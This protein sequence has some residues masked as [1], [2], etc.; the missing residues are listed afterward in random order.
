MGR[1]FE[2]DRSDRDARY[3]PEIRLSGAE[4]EQDEIDLRRETDVFA[5]H[6]RLDGED[7]ETQ[8]AKLRDTLAEDAEGIIHL[9]IPAYRYDFTLNPFVGMGPDI[10]RTYQISRHLDV[11]FLHR[12]M[13]HDILVAGFRSR[14]YV[15]ET[16]RAAFV[17]HIRDTGGIVLQADNTQYDFLAIR[18]APYVAS[19]TTAAFF[20]LYHKQEPHSAERP[21]YPIDVWAIYDAQAYDEVDASYDFRR[22]YRLKDGY[23][24]RASLLGIAQIN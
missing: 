5:D 2:F 17:K 21:H 4:K 1:S 8:L 6:E 19:D 16:G 24:R 10:I 7:D 9:E 20:T 3:N 14:D 23:D 11:V 13:F 12:F 22:A 18:F 15:E